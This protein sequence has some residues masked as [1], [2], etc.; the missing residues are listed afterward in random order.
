MSD[1]IIVENVAS[2]TI[3]ST[4]DHAKLIEENADLKEENSLLVETNEEFQ[5]IFGKYGL[6]YNPVDS[7][8]DIAKTL[9]ENLILRKELVKLG[10]PQ[11]CYDIG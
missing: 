11:T 9:E 4:C 7:L 10:S 8:C 2:S 6:K 1:P 3:S 5:T